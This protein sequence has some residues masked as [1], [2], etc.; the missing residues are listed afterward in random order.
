MSLYSWQGVRRYLPALG[1]NEAHADRCATERV[2]SMNRICITVL[3]QVTSFQQRIEL[4][5]HDAFCIGAHFVGRR[6]Q[7]IIVLAS[8]DTAP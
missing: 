2:D 8:L 3:F 1:E 6:K 4:A 7:K 5:L